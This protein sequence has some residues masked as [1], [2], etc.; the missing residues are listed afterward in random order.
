MSRSSYG[1]TEQQL[2]NLNNLVCER[3]CC[4][5]EENRKILE[6]FVPRKGC[7]QKLIDDAIALGFE[8]D[9]SNR[10]A[11]YLVKDKDGLGYLFFS[12]RCGSSYDNELTD[13]WYKARRED[14]GKQQNQAESQF[15]TQAMLR[16]GNQ[17]SEL[18]DAQ[19]DL[20]KD[21]LN[22]E[23]LCLKRVQ[24]AFGAV[25]IVQ[26]CQNKAAVERWKAFDP[27]MSFPDRRMGEVLFWHYVVT[28]VLDATQLVGAEILYLFAADKSQ[29]GTLCAHYRR[30]GFRTPGEFL[31]S[32]RKKD[33]E[34]CTIYK[35]RYDLT[36]V[37][38]MCSIDG[39]QKAKEDFFAD[40]NMP[41]EECE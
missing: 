36:S 32:Q 17:L 41:A 21:W 22:D 12:L 10:L 14:L 11:F 37:L 40:F 29:V 23:E 34:G 39:L 33:G 19:K 3:F 15:D 28:K 18:D 20:A 27:P 16:I 24:T 35:P 13:A 8:L 6:G 25:E 1:I 5:A 26:F 9:R 30:L 4:H 31:A 2:A 7:G 38:M